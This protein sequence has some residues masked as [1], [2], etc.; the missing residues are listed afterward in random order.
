[1]LTTFTEIKQE[2][3]N[4]WH[5]LADNQY[6]TDLLSEWADSTCPIYNNEIIAE[7]T[8]MPSEFDNFWQEYGEAGNR[9]I[10]ELMQV[11]LYNYYQH[12]YNRAYNELADEKDA[13]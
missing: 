9:G 4:D 10:V 13:N 12:L 5:L 3:D 7:W 2:I 8:E 11:D 1:M 6:P